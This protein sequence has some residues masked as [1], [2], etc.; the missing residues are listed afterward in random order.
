MIEHR[1]GIGEKAVA[2]TFDDGPSDWTGSILDLLDDHS[3]TA[4]FFVL[5]CA[6]AGREETLKRIL[7]S[8]SEIG[9]HTYNHPGLTAVPDADVREQINR[10]TALVEQVT[11]VELRYW[12]APYFGSDARVRSI[13]ASSGLEEVWYSVITHDYAWPAEKTAAYVLE[14]VQP[15]SIVDLH[16]GRAPTDGPGQSL[17]TR[18]ETV[19]AVAEILR[20]FDSRGYRCVTVS[21]LLLLE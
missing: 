19:K 16:D 14:N 5:G 20:D 12:R 13:L 10:T 9:N 6:V 21:E 4:T 7:S 18:D 17:P 8:G 15:G 11:G 3:G 1:H 2:L